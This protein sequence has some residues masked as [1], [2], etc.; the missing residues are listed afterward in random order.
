MRNSRIARNIAIA[1]GVVVLAFFILLVTAKP[2]G[3]RGISTPLLGNPAPAVSSPLI[4]GGTFDLA[5]RK[6]SWVV[7]NFFNSTCVPCRIEHP[8]LVAFQKNQSVLENSAELITVVNDDSDAAVAEF[9]KKNGGDWPKVTDP[10]G[11]IAVAFGVAKV[12]ETWVIDPSGFVRLRIA[13]EVTSGFLSAKLAEL[14]SE[15]AAP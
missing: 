4:G 6:G 12:P 14:Q 1:T 8:Q 11:A 9:F 10:D 2:R 13:G 3:E 7:L 15:L 5:R